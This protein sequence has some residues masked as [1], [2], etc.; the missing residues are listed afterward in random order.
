M[1]ENHPFARY[2]AALGRGPGKSRDL[3]E[4]E[5][6]EAMRSILR[7]E[8]EPEQLGAFLMLMRYKRETPAELA[9]FVRAA[10]ETLDQPGAMPGGAPVAELDWPSYADRHKQLPWFVLAALLLAENGVTILMHG[11]DGRGEA[12]IST[13]AAL[14]ALGIRPSTSLEEAAREIGR[15]GFAYLRLESLSPALGRLFGLRPILGLRS[16]VNSLAR[17]LN[18]MAAPHLIQ[19]VFHPAYMPL[20][21][22]AAVRLGQPH[23]AIFKGG[24]GEAQRNPD[25]ACLVALV[26]DG[27]AA[28]QEWPALTPG[29]RIKWREEPLELARIAA[30]WSGKLD[31]P[32]PV[33]AVTG[34]A[35][36][37]LALVGRAPG[38]EAARELAVDM[39][40]AR[41]RAKFAAC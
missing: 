41:D 33:A 27:A 7:G 28:E 13:P 10:R 2:V 11:I 29:A 9:G 14:A 32:A 36:L 40:E 20:H 6:R 22:E 25:K 8:V 23:A 30:L 4:D 5:A 1:A 17:E 18:P 38:V 34:T 26:R 37:A 15:G 35:A 3:Q 39:W 31:E 19:G 12:P 16:P 21:Q 24:G